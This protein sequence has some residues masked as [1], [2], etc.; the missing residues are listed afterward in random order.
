MDILIMF[1]LLAIALLVWR[2]AKGG[3]I[4]GLWV[5][6]VLAVLGL[7][8]YHVTSVLDLSF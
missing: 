1:L 7:F 6:G 3:M 4:L 8:R 5:V 2:G